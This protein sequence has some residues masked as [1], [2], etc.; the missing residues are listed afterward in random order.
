MRGEL[1][2]E[3]PPQELLE[4]A[5]RAG[6]RSGCSK[7][8]RGVAAL[9]R[10]DRLLVEG[11]NHP[12]VGTCDGSEACRRDCGKVCVH[13]EQMALVIA[14]H[15]VGA[16][17]LHV[18]VVNGCGVPGGPPS[19]AECSKL[20]LAAGIANMWLWEEAR[21]GWVRYTA[22]DFHLATLEKLELHTT[23]ARAP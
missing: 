21:G 7:S 4:A 17:V 12:A 19:C 6:R 16:E 14:P 22:R 3:G 15:L 23:I 2:P 18:K 13:A 8:K 5:L 10:G 1:V 9:L 11:W 20:L